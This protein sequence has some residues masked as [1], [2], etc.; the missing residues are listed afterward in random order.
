[1]NIVLVTGSR[2]FT[3]AVVVDAALDIAAPDIVVH[4]AARGADSLAA[5]WCGR[6][7]N[8]YE[9][10]VPAKWDTLGRSAGMAR[11]AVMLRLQP[12]LVLSFF[13]THAANVGT[14]GMV[15][16]AERAGVRVESFWA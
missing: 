2:E 12:T 13:A 9:I 10:A 3:D 4:G 6:H 5:A 16:L 8:V 15:R 14:T 7:P 11:N 1:M